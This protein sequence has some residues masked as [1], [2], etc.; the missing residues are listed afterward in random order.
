MRYALFHMKTASAVMSILLAA[1]WHADA[2]LV[3]EWEYDLP[4]SGIAPSYAHASFVSRMRERH[5]GSSHLGVQR[6][7]LTLPLSDPRRSGG[8]GW[9]F[10]AQF[11]VKATL[12][13]VDGSLDLHRDELFAFALPLSLVKPLAG[14]RLL[15][16]ALA[17]E[18]ASDMS[19]SARGYDLAAFVDYKVKASDTLSYGVGLG[20]SPRF[21][22]YWVVPFFSLAWQ[23]A[24]DWEVRLRGYRLT[25]L[26]DLSPHLA[27]GPF[28][29]GAGG[30]WMVKTD[31]GDRIFRIRSL[32]AGVM[33]EYDFSH[34]GQRKRIVTAALGTTLATSAQFCE[35]GGSKDAYET[36]HYRPGIYAAI[37]VDF[38]F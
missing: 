32:V 4:D 2:R 22:Q 25:A 15:T 7:A 20:M 1:C 34:E 3:E 23:P 19:G 29:E 8:K 36:H 38:R 6:Y 11:D 17:P 28:M 24:P 37:G 35:R 21:A 14:D 30:V 26:Y 5:G 9:M 16:V 31:R 27:V 18:M 13:D 10:N 12:L 33:G